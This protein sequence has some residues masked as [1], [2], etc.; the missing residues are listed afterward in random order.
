MNKIFLLSLLFSC[1][2]AENISQR[3][4]K[5]EQERI[6]HLQD[7]TPK[8]EISLQS[9]IQESAD[10]IILN[11]N[12]CF[13]IDEIILDDKG[14]LKFQK[15]LAKVIDKL[16]FKSGVCLGEKSINAIIRAMNNEIIKN[17]YITSLINIKPLN[18][19]SRRIEFELNLG[20]IDKISINNEDSNRT[21]SML[22][23][24][25]GELDHNKT[26]SIRNLEQALENI[27]NAT[28]GDV[29]ISLSPSNKLN[30]TDVLITRSSKALP[31]SL[32]LNMDNY[33]SKQTGRHQASIGVSAANLIG[34]NEIYTLSLGRD[35]FNKERTKISENSKKGSSHNHYINFSIPF[36]YFNL[37]YT[38]SGYY[39]N[40][41]IPGIN[42]LYEYSGRSR[43]QNLGLGYM[44]HRDQSMKLS[45]F[46]N[47]FKRNS[48]NYIESYELTN[49]RRVTSGYEI[50]IRS[51]LNMPNSAL[52]AQ[53]S[54]KRGTGM[55]GAI[56]APEQ[57]I[58]EGT[59]R[60]KIWL[61][62]LG[63]K[64]RFKSLTY[65]TALHAQYNKT[66]LTIQDRLSIGGIYSVRGFSGQMSLVGQ[67][68]IYMR[69]T[70][71]Y[72]YT[73]KHLVYLA[74]DAGAVY[75]TNSAHI[76]SNKLV[77]SG[78]GLKGNFDL[79]GQTLSYDLLASTPIYKPE[80]FKTDKVHLGFS[81][82]AG[83]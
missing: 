8:A 52:T 48:K 12:P 73:N 81:V 55:L 33:G 41:I 51:N 67:K 14:N 50:G 56:P 37:N 18:L 35:F 44:L 61:L 23:S 17:G 7:N 11:E 1:I 16:K 43:V 54:Y 70:L 40:Q 66:P 20:M 82:A 9:D 63:Y 29:G 83:F 78:I 36:G 3:E 77:G 76:S 53:I 60:M 74:L 59:S 31:I 19:K 69:N 13:E 2:F 80:Y 62:D 57:K 6:K 30:Y 72:G 64:H 49:Q 39:Y 5:N 21:K 38:N 15:Y 68:G 46:L 65:D 75:S 10:L 34:F 58:N 42:S 71:S 4:F 27:S 79:L 22:F 25:F 32:K 26:L 45:T 24:A 28:F 47:L